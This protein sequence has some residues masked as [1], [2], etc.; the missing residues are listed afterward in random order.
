[1]EDDKEAEKTAKRLAEVE[2]PPT[3]ETKEQAEVSK[4][5]PPQVKESE[6]AEKPEETPEPKVEAEE[7]S[8]EQSKDGKAFAKMR[9]R[10]KELEAQVASQGAEPVEGVFPQQQFETPTQ[11]ATPEVG[12][13]I[14]EAGEIDPVKFKQDVQTNAVQQAS[15][16]AKQQIDEFRQTQ[17][18]LKSYPELD[19]DTKAH[20]KEFYQA[21]RGQLL[22][23]MMRP[24]EYDG[25]TLTYKEAADKV[26]GLS[27]KARKEV[28]AEGAD[29]AMKEV[30][31]KEA[32]SLEAGGSS[33]RAASAESTTDVE[34]LSQQTRRGGRKGNEAAAER[35]KKLGI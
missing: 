26:V 13:Y 31:D 4:E 6:T 2:S 12:Q 35:L 15:T 8:Q 27:S 25:K 30:A 23:S 7:A 14:N 18:A 19:P 11:Q 10:V 3:K 24:N 28:E 22:D 21:V 17:E 32:A 16:I 1:M 34:V 29:K 33:G 5:E 9:N 20:D